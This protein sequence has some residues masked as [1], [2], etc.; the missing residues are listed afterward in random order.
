MASH[1]L[2]AGQTISGL[3]QISTNNLNF[4]GASEL[5]WPRN[6][7]IRVYAKCNLHT[8]EIKQMTNGNKVE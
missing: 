7:T 6:L 3:T 8:Y 2:P 4:V 1:G 5:E